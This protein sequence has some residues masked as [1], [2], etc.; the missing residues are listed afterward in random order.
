MSK[1][2]GPSTFCVLPGSM[3]TRSSATSTYGLN[4][5]QVVLLPDPQE[6]PCA[7]L[8]EAHLPL[9]AVDVEILHTAHPLPFCVVDVL[10][11]H[12]IL[13]VCGDEVRVA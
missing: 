5:H 4:R 13:R 11:A 12:V 10:A 3:V 2:A 8:Q 7:H 6:T 9:L 1:G